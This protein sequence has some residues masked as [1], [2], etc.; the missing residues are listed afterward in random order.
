MGRVAKLARAG[1]AEKY[2]TRERNR[3]KI[4]G[5]TRGYYRKFGVC[6]ICLRELALRGHVPGMKKSSW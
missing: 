3:C 2:R 1:R 6:R 5:R 4:C